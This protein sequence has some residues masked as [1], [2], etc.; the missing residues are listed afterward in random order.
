MSRTIPKRKAGKAKMSDQGIG[1]APVFGFGILLCM[2]AGCVPKPCLQYCMRTESGVRYPSAEKFKE[3]SGRGIDHE[4]SQFSAI[5]GHCVTK[6][7]IREGG[8][9]ASQVT[10]ADRWRTFHV[11]T[12]LEVLKTSGALVPPCCFPHSA[13]AAQR[14]TPALCL[15]RGRLLGVL[16]G[17]SA[18]LHALRQRFPAF[19]RA[20]R[21]YCTTV[22]LPIN[23][24]VG[25][26]DHVLLQPAR[27]HLRVGRRRDLP[28]LAREVSM[29]A[30]CLR[31]RRVR[32][33]LAM[34]HSSV[35][36]SACWNSVGALISDPFHGSIA[37]PACPPVNASRAALRP[38]AHDSGPG[39]L[40]TPYLYDSCIRELGRGLARYSKG[41]AYQLLP[42]SSGSASLAE[43]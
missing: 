41:S 6:S 27:A 32:S 24:H 12:R 31:P 29:H 39:W 2:R 17:R 4:P 43:P 40:A 37:L 10:T 20:L 30:R 42:V 38:P 35:L 18:S 7:R 15:R 22:R 21:R 26:L 13:Q 11:T 19:V 25:L 14:V 8:A 33:M 9:A 5:S 3:F 34:A 1:E 23:V 36:P 16:L 28:V